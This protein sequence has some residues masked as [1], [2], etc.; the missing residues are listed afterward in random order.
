MDVRNKNG[1][2]IRKFPGSGSG[3]F[4]DV[5]SAGGIIFGTD[6]EILLPQ[7]ENRNSIL[8]FAETAKIS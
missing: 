7:I 3:R 1:D 2:R 5:V 6:L 8:N 4:K